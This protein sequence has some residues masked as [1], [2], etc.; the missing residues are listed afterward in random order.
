MLCREL[1]YGELRYTERVSSEKDPRS[2]GDLIVFYVMTRLRTIGS[3]YIESRRVLGAMLYGKNLL[4][5]I[6]NG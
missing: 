3:F 2:A 5:W 1:R 6:V 4:G